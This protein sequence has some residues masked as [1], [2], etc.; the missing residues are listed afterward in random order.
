MSSPARASKHG[1]HARRAWAR[2]PLAA[3]AL[4]GA[5]RTSAEQKQREATEAAEEGAR[6]TTLT[7]GTIE[8]D[9]GATGDALRA[10][11]EA[12]VAFRRE[13]SEYRAKIRERLDD[14]EQELGR[15]RAKHRGRV[16]S[17]LEATRA[18]LASDLQAIDRSTEAD[19][20]TLRPRLDRALAPKPEVSP[21]SDRPWGP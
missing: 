11:S 4:V 20:A 12:I 15:A 19:W 13:Q 21:R 3:L 2:L 17:D 5:C 7:S 18:D 14:V 6:E 9:A 16:V 1:P 10:R 8:V